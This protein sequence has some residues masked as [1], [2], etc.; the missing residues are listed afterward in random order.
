M[1]DPYSGAA[2]ADLTTGDLELFAQQS[3]LPAQR[4]GGAQVIEGES[5]QGATLRARPTPHPVA[6]SLKSGLEASEDPLEHVAALP[7]LT[8]LVNPCEGRGQSRFAR[9]LKGGWLK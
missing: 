5:D 4:A 6:K 7:R 1:H 8:P 3:V 2:A 9:I